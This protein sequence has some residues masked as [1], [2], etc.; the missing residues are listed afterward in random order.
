MVKK[1]DGI[2]KE[3]AE[4]LDLNPIA[5]R[6]LRYDPL[7]R[8]EA[9]LACKVHLAALAPKPKAEKKTTSKDK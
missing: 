6:K 4:L 7:I 2:I 1:L 3:C 8:L 5:R 9:A